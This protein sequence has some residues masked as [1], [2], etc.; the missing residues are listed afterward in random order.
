MPRCIAFQ[1]KASDLQ[2]SSHSLF[3]HSLCGRHSKAKSPRLWVPVESPDTRSA[4]MIQALVRGWFV[5]KYLRNCGPGVLHRVDLA[6]GEDVITYDSADRVSPMNYFAFVE[7]GKTWWFDFSSLWHWTTKSLE[8][9]NPYTRVPLSTET[10]KRLREM[11]FLRKRR[12]LPIPDN[13]NTNLE[14]LKARWNTVCQ[15]F[16]DNGFT[17][18]TPEH[19]ARLAKEDYVALFRMIRADIPTSFRRHNRG[20]NIA[21]IMCTHGLSPSMTSMSESLYILTS[22]RILLR[23]MTTHKDPYV[24]VFIVL[25]ALYR[26]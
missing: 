22:L 14:R 6:N 12:G 3:G 10:R 20:A 26:C 25:A 15:I 18:I 24:M 7:N 21:M 16:V 9:H 23:I 19:F 2:C 1:N 17:E 4:R 8:P 11:W 5:R 13:D